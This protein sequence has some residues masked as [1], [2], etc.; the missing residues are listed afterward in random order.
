ML[1]HYDFYRGGYSMAW[2]ILE[3]DTDPDEVSVDEL[4]ASRSIEVTLTAKE[5]FEGAGFLGVGWRARTMNGADI[6]FCHIDP[7]NFAVTPGSCTERQTEPKAF[8]CCVAR[9]RPLESRAVT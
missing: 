6:W 2:A 3:A 9:G 4:L 5:G 7:A 8:S 1:L